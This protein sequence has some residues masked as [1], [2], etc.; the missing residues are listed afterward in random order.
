MNQNN[1]NAQFDLRFPSPDRVS[2][3]RKPPISMRYR[4]LMGSSEGRVWTPITLIEVGETTPNARLFSQ[5]ISM[6]A[7][8]L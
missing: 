6:E 2:S 8:I 7:F 4:P 1:T 5:M 3:N